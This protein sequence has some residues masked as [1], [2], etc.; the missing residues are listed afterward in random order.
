MP[1]A[2]NTNHISKYMIIIYISDNHYSMEKI[3]CET[4]NILYTIPSL[5][6]FQ[7][8]GL[9]NYLSNICSY[10]PFIFYTNILNIETNQIKK[11]KKNGK[12]RIYHNIKKRNR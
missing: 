9:M 2:E 1:M 3:A 8:P 12:K 11:L 7:K 10:I 4:R 5:V 6:I